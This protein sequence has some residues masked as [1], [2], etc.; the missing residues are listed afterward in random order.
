MDGLTPRLRRWQAQGSTV[1]LGRHRLFVAQAGHQGSV[2]LLIHGY[3]TSSYDWHLLWEPLATSHRLIAPDLLGMGFSDKPADHAYGIE[4]YA[5][6]LDALLD[7]FDVRQLHIVAH[8]LGVSV[9]QE[10]LARRQTTSS[11]QR[12]LSLTLLNGG[13]CPEAY[14][15]RLLQHLLSSR[16]GRWIAPRIP[17]KAFERTITRLF[18]A[19][20][21]PSAAL[22][23]EFWALV[24][25]HNG[26]AISHKT[27]RFYIDRMVLRDRLV[28]PL[29]RQVVPV[30]LINGAADPNSGA[31]M[32]QRYRT[33]VPDADVVS[34][35]GIGH[36]PQIEAPEQVIHALQ[37]FLQLHDQ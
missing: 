35:P 28:E 22:L 26:R 11:S 16:W 36:W 4:N 25:L 27:G 5:D 31:H 13:V 1:A 29:L 32:V 33:L 23:E 12:V 34:L 19:Q 24:N 8:D 21:L 7:R 3:P 37:Q 17:Q 30:R 10:M 14:Q 6:L 18:G 15:P 2:V 20:T 9:A